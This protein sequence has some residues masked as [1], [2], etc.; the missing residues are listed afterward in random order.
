MRALTREDLDDVTVLQ[1]A[2]QRN[3][4]AIYLGPGASIA[5]GRV[6]GICKVDRRS[7]S[8]QLNDLAH[9]RE[10]VNV[11]RIEVELQRLDEVLGIRVIL[12]FAN[13]RQEKLFDRL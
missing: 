3:D 6:N 4:T 5:N 11:L 12:R 1:L 2:A 8:R 7:A 9:R 10:G 13:K